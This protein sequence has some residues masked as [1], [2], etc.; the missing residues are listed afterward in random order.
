VIAELHAQG[1]SDG[2]WDFLEPHAFEIMKR[3]R[4]PEIDALHVMEG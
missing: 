3:I 4:R 2:H 1:L